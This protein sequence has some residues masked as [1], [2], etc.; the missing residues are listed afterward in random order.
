MR[1]GVVCEGPTDFCSIEAFFGRSLNEVG[2]QAEF[3]AIQPSTDDT[4][5]AGWGNALLWLE[6]NPPDYRIQNYFGGGLF[7][8]A[9]SRQPLDAMIV[10]LDSDI[11]GHP[12]FEAFVFDNYNY[13]VSIPLDPLSRGNE[14]RNILFLAAKFN[15]MTNADQHK[16]VLTPAVESTETWCIAAFNALPAEYEKVAGQ[17]LID[18]FMSALERSESRF[19]SLPYAHISKNIQRREKFCSTH[20]VGSSRILATCLH[21]ANAHTQLVTLSD[22]LTTS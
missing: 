13:R 1:V 7:A 2:V 21:F 9:L 8:G 5:P 20:A 22:A 6:K 11:L 3:H 18:Q 14:I 10:Q 16:H 15:E 12:S 19:P 4:Q 17:Q